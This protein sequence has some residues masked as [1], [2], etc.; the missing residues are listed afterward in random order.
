MKQ[1]LFGILCIALLALALSACGASDTASGSDISG[2]SLQ[3][4]ATIFPE[5]DWVNA[6]LG[7]ASADVEVTMLL[8]D[9][10][11]LHSY[12]P[13]VSDIATVS[14]CDMLIYVG[15]ESDEWIEDALEESV[16]EDMIVVNLMEVLG[17][18][19]REEEDVEGMEAETSSDSEEIEYDEHVWLSLQ[20]AQ[21]LVSAIAE[22]LSEADVANADTYAA[23]AVSYQESLKTLDAAYAEALAQ[24][25]G[26]TLIFGDRFPFLYLLK[27]YGLNYYA[28]FAGCSAETEASFETI[29]FLAQQMDAL[30]ANYV[31]VT[32]SADQRIAK[33]IIEN[34]ETA[35]QEILVL[36][37]MQS[38]TAQ[39]VAAGETYLSVM[40]SNLEVLTTALQ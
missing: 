16:N 32:E 39:D 33:T 17:E 7:E 9:G 40:E 24:A 14:S 22:A 23:N 26:D 38:V 10:V 12:Q 18:N 35:D 13:T 21:V 3:I 19:V 25:S 2:D 28:A 6:V 29:T 34:T 37:S 20:N 5:Y 31:L 30:G 1:R 27:D 15:G 36:D 11:D 8:D 4:V